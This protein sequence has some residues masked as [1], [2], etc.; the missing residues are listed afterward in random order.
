IHRDSL[1][2]ILALDSR[3]LTLDYITFRLS[4]LDSRPIMH[5]QEAIDLAREALMVATLISAPVLLAGM[6]VGLIV[7]LIQ[8]LTQIQEQTVAFVPKLIAMVLALG[9]SLPWVLT[10]LIE[11][12]HELIANIPNSL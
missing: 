1:E 3:L 2:I 11:Y 6:I 7:G 4:T 12:S 10:R 5:P 9:I 8:A